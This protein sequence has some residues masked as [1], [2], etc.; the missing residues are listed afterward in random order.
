MPSSTLAGASAVGFEERLASAISRR[1]SEPRYN[2]WF[3]N[4]TKFVHLG[5][6]IVVG[7]PNLYFHDWLQ[8]TFGLE[9]RASVAE[10]FARSHRSLTRGSSID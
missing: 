3:R 4:H 7:V 5:D 10:I 2:L 6:A 1:I 9:V 8:N